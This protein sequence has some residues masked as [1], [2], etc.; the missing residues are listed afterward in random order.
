[1]L[2]ATAS[3]TPFRPLP[4]TTPRIWLVL[5][6]LEEL[7]QLLPDHSLG[8][9]LKARNIRVNAVAPDPAHTSLR[10][11]SLPAEQMDGSGKSAG[12]EHSELATRFVFLASKDSEL[13]Y[14]QI[15]DSYP[16]G[17]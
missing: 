4:S 16:L 1:M 10:P 12:V 9:N 8:K 15:L 5:F 6:P 17:D 13:Y 14:G 3:L 2:T 7:L 11:V